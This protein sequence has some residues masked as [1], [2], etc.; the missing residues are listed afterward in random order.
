MLATQAVFA[1]NLK[2]LR[3]ARVASIY[4]SARDQ[5]LGKLNGW[6][7]EGGKLACEDGMRVQVVVGPDE[8]YP[9]DA[10][11][12]CPRVPLEG[13]FDLVIAVDVY[14]AGMQG[15]VTPSVLKQWCGLSRKGEVFLI[16][17]MFPG[18]FGC[19][20]VPG[21]Q[22]PVEG[23]WT[24][25]AEGMVNFSPDQADFCYPRHHDLEWVRK[26]A[27]EGLSCTL[28]EV[29][30]P[31]VVVKVALDSAF[32]K[33]VAVI[34]PFPTV[35]VAERLTMP[36]RGLWFWWMRTVGVG[37]FRFAFSEAEL[38]HTIG[39]TVHTQTL[40]ALRP[41]YQL[42]TAGGHNM[43]MAVS[44][45]KTA[46]MLDPVAKEVAKRYPLAIEQAVVGTADAV[47]FSSKTETALRYGGLRYDHAQE[48][49]EIV[50]ARQ[51]VVA[52]GYY[53]I[54]PA[55]I[56]RAV[57][58]VALLVGAMHFALSLG[59][60]GHITVDGVVVERSEWWG[61]LIVAAFIGM[62][63]IITHRRQ[64]RKGTSGLFKAWSEQHEDCEIQEDCVI[65]FEALPA[66]AVVRSVQV[67]SMV[68]TVGLGEISVQVDGQSVTVE[69]AFELLKDDEPTKV[70]YPVAITCGLLW[71]PDRSDVN[72]LA[73]IV[74]RLHTAVKQEEVGAWDCTTASL[75][76]VIPEAIHTPW[77]LEDCAKAMGGAK[78]INLLRSMSEVE[79]GERTRSTKSVMVKW[80]E[81][82]YLREIRGLLSI[83]PRS[84]VVLSNELHSMLA[85]DAR[86]FSDAL[87]H[88][89]DGK[90]F[91]GKRIYYAAG[92]SEAKLDQVGVHLYGHEPFIAVSGDDS[93]C[94]LVRPAYRLPNGRTVSVPTLY[95]GDFTAMDQSEKT[96]ALNMHASIM[97]RAG[98]N[99]WLID[100][101]LSVCA[102]RYKYRGKRLVIKGT[103]GSQLATGIDM[104]TV[105]N[106]LTT[107]A[108]V[109]CR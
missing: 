84:I 62:A 91:G 74:Q 102:M 20:Q 96:G 99:G 2:G 25:D 93:V 3:T 100:L 29:F 72:A 78:G 57:F 45:C 82:I 15:P 36:R 101:Y 52:S 65:G 81:T 35:G 95:E 73:A 70:I 27:V 43:D 83:K 76:S 67:E 51:P 85:P 9:G 32:V 38:T 21:Y 5:S 75:L 24:K 55:R 23:V 88:L 12:T 39:A 41:L 30:G 49:E 10:G 16:M 108:L 92:Y 71:Q 34:L 63:Y 22:G 14:W 89:F 4:G 48:E 6:T 64:Q 7:K 11:R 106:S 90:L 97:R 59:V 46:I 56:R 8:T 44:M 77:E 13:L 58:A 1:V 68:C 54:P 60:R 98:V 105:C 86:G 107:I 42:K 109:D 33:D 37:P 28:M 26:R 53:R 50:A 19:D 80:N 40:A 103:V 79:R 61:G 69:E 87:H 104:T 31:Y 66:G 18:Q 17:R 94:C 47:L